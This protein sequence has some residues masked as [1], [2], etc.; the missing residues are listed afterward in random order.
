M[1]QAVQYEA[2]GDFS[3]A[4]RCYRNLIDSSSVSKKLKRRA[5]GKIR[6]IFMRK[7]I[8]SNDFIQ[9]GLMYYLGEGV[10]QD[11]YEAKKWYEKAIKKDQNKFAYEGLGLLYEF[12]HDIEKD[13]I[14]ATKYYQQA[15]DKGYTEAQEH[16]D[17][18]RQ[19]PDI[20]GNDC[21]S[22]GW[23]YHDKQNYSEAKKW[24]E[25]A[26]QKD[27]N[28][29]AYE[30]LGVLYESGLGTS[31]NLVIAVKCYQQALDLDKDL[32]TAQKNLTEMKQ[33]P[34]ISGNDCSSIGWIYYAG[35][36]VIQDG[37]EAKKWYDKAI[38]KDQNKF[39]YEGLGLL[40]ENGLG[41]SKNLVIAAKYYQQA[42]DLDKDYVKAQEGLD[43]VRQNLD[44]S[45]DDCNSIGAMY[46][47][48][49]GISQNH[50]QAKEWY[51]KVK[52]WNKFAYH[53][54]GL[55]YAY[56]LGVSKNL[57]IATKCYQQA[58]DLD[59]DFVPVQEKLADVVKQNPDISGDDCW[60]IGRMYQNGEGIFINHLQAKAWYEKA[61][62]KGG[63]KFAYNSLGILYAYSLGVSKNLVIAAKY[64]QQALDLDKYFDPAQRNL[65]EVDDVKRN[66]DISGDEMNNIGVMYANGTEVQQNYLQAK[67]WY[68]KA[69]AKD[70]NKWA[71][72]N[73]GVLYENG[74]DV[75][76]DLKKAGEN[77]RQA[78]AKGHAEVENDLMRVKDKAQP[79]KDLMTF[80]GLT[81]I[82]M[83]IYLAVG[84]GGLLSTVGIG[85]MS[86]GFS[87]F[88]YSLGSEA[89]QFTMLDYGKNCATGAGKGVVMHTGVMPIVGPIVK[90]ASSTLSAFGSTLGISGGSSGIATSTGI[91]PKAISSLSSMA[92]SVS[93]VVS[94]TVD[95]VSSCPLV[96]D[97]L[98]GAAFSSALPSVP[99]NRFI[100]GKE[101]SDTLKEAGKEAIAGFGG[102][103]VR[104]VTGIVLG[105]ETKK[106]IEN[107]VIGNAIIN[108]M[109][110]ATD[111]AT[112]YA[113]SN[114]LH[115]K[116]LTEG[117]LEAVL[118]KATI[119]S[120]VKG[121]QTYK[122][123]IEQIGFQTKSSQQVTQ[124]RLQSKGE[125]KSGTVSSQ[126]QALKVSQPS[127]L[128]SSSSCNNSNSL[129]STVNRQINQ[130]ETTRTKRKT[131]EQASCGEKGTR[132]S[133]RLLAA[134]KK[135]KKD[136]E[137]SI[138]INSNKNFN[139]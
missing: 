84:S 75:P 64:Y 119:G 7:N 45:G 26:T 55:L 116:N 21:Y 53:N 23:M 70:K 77:Y 44:I 27:Q 42:L 137:S 90:G 56:G 117:M 80:L 66:P 5:R 36:G 107:H 19:H 114:K 139:L 72:R 134:R 14:T 99:Y 3:A 95:V 97:S 41:V 78:I 92:S 118:T 54:L 121:I 102:G 24:Y 31:K 82:G 136:V 30:G 113:A 48:G 67:K 87:G 13:L 28:K 88:I 123:P 65:T 132:F 60:S 133:P 33:N 100:Q 74:Q 22:F 93:S 47:N 20:S 104:S 35:L 37:S 10:I 40:Y 125:C 86:S 9:I 39:A 76:E 138:L 101:W 94:S 34:D 112:Y 62:H 58:L 49:E 111:T 6:S 11:D 129:F 83:G 131:R 81:Q 29:F 68:E 130:S 73:L 89:D 12:S 120:T 57:V 128:S 79:R 71:Y 46:H 126:R 91:I 1:R 109:S 32:D 115:E 85:L 135:V 25:E 108:G 105:E 16:L 127:S 124:T 59:K 110:E 63:N 51:E 122:T 17:R 50:F 103:L 8:D 96:S 18:V 15:F 69:I 52:G 2:Q 43:R 38:Q 61:I 98:S 106:I 4:I